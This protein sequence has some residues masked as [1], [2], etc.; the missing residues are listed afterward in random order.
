MKDNLKISLVQ[1]NIS[2]SKK[3]NFEKLEKLFSEI[4][5]TDIILLPEMFNTSFLPEQT[6]LAES[7]NGDTVTWMK[8]IAKKYNCS[9]VGTLMIIQNEKLYNRLVW[10]K[11]NLEILTYDKRHLFSIAKEDIYLN[12]GDKKIVIEQDGWKI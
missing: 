3:E 6:D 1:F 11:T 8:K 12:K 7:M 9:V 4:V 5:C 2:Q 10:I